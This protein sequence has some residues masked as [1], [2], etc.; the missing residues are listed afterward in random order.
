MTPPS[1]HR[2]PRPRADLDVTTSH[3]DRVRRFSCN[4]LQLQRPEMAQDTSRLTSLPPEILHDVL[5]WLGLADL[6]TLPRVSRALR[7]FLRDNQPLYRD[8]YLKSLVR[9]VH[10]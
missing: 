8:V 10:P 6:V 5:T 2:E 9:S 4:L 1:T 3:Q 7:I